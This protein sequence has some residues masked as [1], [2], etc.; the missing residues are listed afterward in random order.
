MT[1]PARRGR[2]PTTRKVDVTEHERVQLLALARSPDAMVARRASAVLVLDRDVTYLEASRETGMSVAGLHRL[3]WRFRGHRMKCV[4]RR[5][6]QR[7]PAVCGPRIKALSPD[8]KTLLETPPPPSPTGKW[9]LRALARV[10]V[11]TG[12]TDSISRES[13]RLA[14]KLIEGEA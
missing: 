3:A 13:M 5:K 6:R 12:K 11:E 8:I 9:T 7:Y 4:L 2:K 1:T 10:M 14:M